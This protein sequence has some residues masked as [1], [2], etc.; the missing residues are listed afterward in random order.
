MGRC[1]YVGV[2]MPALRVPGAIFCG[3]CVPSLCRHWQLGCS[4]CSA[5]RYVSDFL[6]VRNTLCGFLLLQLLYVSI[7]TDVKCGWVGL[8]RT[9]I[10]IVQ[11]DGIFLTEQSRM[12]YQNVVK[13][14][15]MVVISYLKR[16]VLFSLF[17]ERNEQ[18]AK[19][20]LSCD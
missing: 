19:I 14:Y 20:L 4:D 17:C 7:L 18:I 10:H 6:C 3:G 13:S 2:W 8:L 15:L 5:S 12:D 11:E 1:A 9:V 16:T